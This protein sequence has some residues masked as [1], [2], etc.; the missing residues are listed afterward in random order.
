MASHKDTM[1]FLPNSRSAT[2]ALCVSKASE[3]EVNIV[4]L[5]P[6]CNHLA[7]GHLHLLQRVFEDIRWSFAAR[8]RI[9]HFGCLEKA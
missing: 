9:F 8:S 5:D 4:L 1:T 7:K 3:N 6:Q 2:R